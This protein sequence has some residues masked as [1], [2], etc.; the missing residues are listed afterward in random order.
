MML[1]DFTAFAAELCLYMSTVGFM[2]SLQ[3]RIGN[4]G[5]V[6]HTIV[7]LLSEFSCALCKD[8]KGTVRYLPAL[9]MAPLFVAARSIP[10][11]MLPVPVL[12]LVMMRCRARRW[13]AE[14]YTIRTL[15]T[16][17]CT[18]YPLIL[19]LFAAGENFEQLISGSL[20]FFVVWLFLTVLDMRLL[21]NRYIAGLGA[22]FQA[23]NAALLFGVIFIS[24]LLSAKPVVDVTLKV[25]TILWSQIAVP[26]LVVLLYALL[27]LF[28]AAATLIGYF[29]AGWDLDMVTVQMEHAVMENAFEDLEL[30]ETM[31]FLWLARA[32]IAVGIL[33]FVIMAWLI[34]RKLVNQPPA[35]AETSGQMKRER[36]LS[37]EKRPRFA[38]QRTV[39]EGVRTV[40]RKYLVLCKSLLI[41]VDGSIASDVICDRSSPYVGTENAKELRELWLRA[42][43]SN[44]VV[45]PDDAKRARQ[46]L[47]RMTKVAAKSR[48]KQSTS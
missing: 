22:S 23:L 9:I 38:G 28:S 31:P 13:K 37:I 21:R 16:V 11:A 5:M 17:G 26:I 39:S 19:L 32:A 4:D 15:F 36:I 18:L 29:W 25:I 35:A 24:L 20:S 46:L 43:F 45:Q 2:L 10:A 44:T 47:R 3:A 27:I 33:F 30:E 48:Q 12:L 7:M 1:T 14:Y 42:R 8:R 40:Y 6:L 41:P 34:A